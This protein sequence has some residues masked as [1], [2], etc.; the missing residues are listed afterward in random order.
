MAGIPTYSMI[1]NRPHP[2]ASSVYSG[3][4]NFLMTPGDIGILKSTLLPSCGFYFSLSIAAYGIAKVTDHVEIKDWLWPSGQVLNAWWNAIGRPMYETN[5]SLPDAWRGL[6]WTE[7]LL[8][9][10]VTLW[11]TRL[12]ARIVSRSLAR[13]RDDPR[14][15]ACKKDLDFWKLALFRFFLPEAAFLSVISLPVTV[16]FC[17]GD[18]TL[19]LETN[20]LSVIRALG[21]GLFSSGFAL[22]LIADAQLELHRKER[23]DLCRHGVWSLVR[24]PNY[25]GD[26]LVH[27]SFVILNLTDS[28][29]PIVLLGPLANYCFLRLVGGDK[30]GEETQQKRYEASDPHKYAQL[31]DW[32]EEKNSFWPS[33]RDLANPWSLAV[34][35]CGLIGVVLEEFVRTTFTMR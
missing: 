28:F 1:D 25:L 3:R 21:V 18:T 22:E 32:C 30:R 34:L 24:H 29:N 31:K 9:G 20:S 10:G 26:A 35:G 7:K 16:P 5:I 13:G 2:R 12:F 19:S 23:E 15:D 6:T 27:L 17:M 11:G 33:L 14:Y 4:P 8:L